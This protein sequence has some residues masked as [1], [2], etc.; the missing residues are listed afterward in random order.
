L[1]DTT[2]ARNCKQERD[3]ITTNDKRSSRLSCREEKAGRAH[4]Q[5][6]L[7]CD[8]FLIVVRTEVT[9]NHERKP[10]QNGNLDDP[11]GNTH[12][13]ILNHV[14]AKR[15]K[16]KHHQRKRECVCLE[17]AGSKHKRTTPPPPPPPALTLIFMISGLSGRGAGAPS[18]Y[19]HAH[20]ELVII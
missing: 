13:N 8:R 17:R 14:D 7:N 20:G 19:K 3:T 11:S 5:T 1:S 4:V 15:N 2:D 12:T 16:H 9:T 6:K 10:E 18:K